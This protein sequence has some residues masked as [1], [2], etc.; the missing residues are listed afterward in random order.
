M[1]QTVTTTGGLP[2]ED[3]AALAAALATLREVGNPVVRA[4]DL[5][6]R[7]IG[8]AGDA[9]LRRAGLGGNNPA[10]Q[11]VAGIA[12]GRAYDIALLGVD[13]R[14][15]PLPAPPGMAAAAL[16]GIAGG[17]AG[18]AGFLPD[19]AV[20]TLIIMRDVA[21]IA[22][23]EGEDLDSEAT[24]TA[25]VQVFGLRAEDEGGYFSA[26]LMLQ[27]QAAQAI[28]TRVAARWG[29]VLGEKLAVGAVPVA[30]A[31]AAS[32]LNTAFLSHY[33]KLARAHFTIRRLERAHGK[34]SVR[35]AAGLPETPEGDVPFLEA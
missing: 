27:G 12:L 8:R 34:A 21:R 26:R 31:V 18:M 1:G 33:R 7:L 22:R 3:A 16:S 32:V 19:A 24:R 6:G 5:L 25:C 4:A 10:L 9:A 17:M 14:M 35:E 2:A 23:E 11:Q 15:G 29:A 30:G 20:T 28:I 13:G